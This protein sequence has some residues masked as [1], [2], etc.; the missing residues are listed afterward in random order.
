MERTE[1]QQSDVF[2][3]LL[4]PE[5]TEFLLDESSDSLLELPWFPQSIWSPPKQDLNKF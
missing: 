4:D 5:S 1:L 3:R 2:E